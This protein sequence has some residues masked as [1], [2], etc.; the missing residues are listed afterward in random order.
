[1]PS[2]K[3]KASVFN[4]GIKQKRHSMFKKKLVSLV[5]KVWK[6]KKSNACSKWKSHNK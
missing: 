4:E 3:Y 6:E 1:M 2:A 5:N